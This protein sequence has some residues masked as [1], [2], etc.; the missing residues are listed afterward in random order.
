MALAAAY[1]GNGHIG[2]G[3][4]V[5]GGTLDITN[6]GDTVTFVLTR[7]TGD[8]NDTLVLYLDTDSAGGF[9]DTTGLK[10]QQDAG[11]RAISG[12]DGTNG[13]DVVF[14]IVSG[15]GA[16]YA[17]VFDA[18]N[19]AN[20]FSLAAGGDGSLTFV[21]G[22]GGGAPA[23][24]AIFTWTLSLADVGLLPGDTFGLV[25]TYLNS[26]NAFRSNEAIG[27]SDAPAGS[28][29]PG[30]PSTLTFT[31]W[32]TFTSVGCGD[33]VV[34]ATDGEVCDDG[35]RVAGDGCAAD[36]SAVESGWDCPSGGG[37]CTE[38]CGDGA[39]VG[40]EACDDGNTVGGDGCAADCSAVESGWTCATA[41]AACTTTCGDS[42]VAGTEECDD[43]GAVAGDGCSDQCLYEPGYTCDLP[44]GCQA[45]CGT[46]HDFATGVEGWAVV[47]QGTGGAFAWGQVDVVALGL[48]GEPGFET[49]PGA[50]LTTADRVDTF[51][52]KRVAVPAAADTPR[53]ELH[54]TY[55]LDRDGADLSPGC[56]SV[57][58]NPTGD[59]SGPADFQT[60]EATPNAGLAQDAAG[61]D[62]YVQDLSGFAGQTVTVTVGFYDQEVTGT[63]RGAFVDKV[64]VYADLD[65]DGSYEM[66]TQ[67]GCDL[68]VDAD[69][70]GYGASASVDLTACSGGATVD[71]DD[72]VA[73]T[74]PGA[75]E[76]CTNTVDDNC[77]GNTDLA[78]PTC[79][80]DCTNGIDDG[81]NGWADC[82][83]SVCAS[84]PFCDACM[85]GRSWTFDSGPGA[86]VS[87]KDITATSID[88]WQ[89]VAAS[90]TWETGG[91]DS[92]LDAFGAGTHRGHLTLTVSLPSVAQVGPEPVLE[93]TYTHQGDTIVN[94]DVFGVCL[95]DPACTASSPADV[96]V[97]SQDTPSP[98]GPQ[99]ATVPLSAYIG[100][101]VTVTFLYDTVTN[102]KNDN[103]GVRIDAVRIVSDTDADGFYEAD[104]AANCDPCWDAD[105][106]GYGHPDSPDPAQCTFVE[107]DCDDQNVNVHPVAGDSGEVCDTPAD[108]DCDGLINGFDVA[109]CGVEDCAN[110]GDDNGDGTVDCADPV[111]AGDAAC[112]VCATFYDFDSGAEGWQPSDNLPSATGIERGV[113]TANAT[114]P[115]D[116]GWETAL[117]ANVS[118]VGGTGRVI[119]RLSRIIDVPA[120]MPGP[121]LEVVY[122]L[123]GEASTARDLVGVCFLNPADD[124][125]TCDGQVGSLPFVTGANTPNPDPGISTDAQGFD[126]AF[127]PFPASLVGAGGSVLAVVFYDT[128]D[129]SNN[130][131]P[132]LYVASLGVRSDL[133]GDGLYERGDA[134]CDHCL[135]A[136]GDG[137]SSYANAFN[138][139]STCTG[140]GAFDCSLEDCDDTNAVTH[141]N[142][143]EVC[144]DP[145]DNNCDGVVTVDDA[146]CSV[147]GDGTVGAGEECDDHNTDDGDGC[148]SVCKI[149]PG[150]LYVT[151]IH[152]PQPGSNP[153]EQWI[154]LYNSSPS[155]VDLAALDLRLR[156]LVGAEQVFA[157]DCTVLT[158]R[159][160]QPTSFYVITLGAASGSDGVAPDA[161]CGASFVLA[162]GGD[163]L[164][165]R[166]GTTTELDVVDYR[167]FACE[168]G[169][170]SVDGVG[171]SLELDNATGRSSQTNDGA[172]VW[173]LASPD[174]D[175]S[176]SGNHRG[177]PGAAGN[178]AEFACDG[179]DDDCDG[180][181]D[182]ALPDGD[183][184]GICN[185]RDCLPANGA[186]A[187]TTTDPSCADVD[188]DFIT[189]CVDDCL[190]ADGDGYGDG[191]GCIDTDCDDSTA[192]AHPGAVEDANTDAAGGPTCADAVDNDCDGLV[193]CL[194][195]AGCQDHFACTGE[196]CENTIPLSCGDVVERAPLT[197]E[198]PC[199]PGPDAVFSFTNPRDQLVTFEVENI[200]RQR[201]SLNLFVGSCDNSTCSGSTALLQPSCGASDA[202]TVAAAEGETYYLVMDQFEACAGGPAGNAGRVTVRCE[203]LCA[204]CPGGDCTGGVDED[205]D[206]K[207]DC[208]DGD[209][210]ADPNCSGADAD[211]DGVSNALELTC[212]TNP[213]DANSTPSSDDL[214]DLDSPVPDGLLN[215][216]DDDDDGDGVPDAVESLPK[217]QGGTCYLNPEPKNDPTVYPGA[218]KNCF[219]SNV[220]ADCDEKFDTT[221]SECGALEVSCGDG[222]DD[223]GDQLIDCLDS[224]CITDPLCT[225]QDW[226]ADGVSNGFELACNT[227]PKVATSLP[228][229]S[230]AEDPDGDNLPNCSDPDDDGD[231]FPDAEEQVCG[232][233]PLDATSVPVDTDG[234]GQCDASDLDDD[235][236]GAFDD[237][238]GIC[239]SDSKDATST[240]T[241]ATHDLDGDGTCNNQDSDDDGDGWLDLTEQVC[242]TDP[243]VT[244]SNPTDL[245]LDV[246][247]DHVCDALDPDDD[248]DGW[249]DAAELQCLTDPNNA[250][251]VPVDANDDG[252]CDVLD[253]DLDG[254]GWANA[255]EES[256]GTD[257]NDAASN[258]TDL[259]Q[260]Q[261]DDKLCDALDDDDDGDGW[262]DATEVACKTDPSDGAS[263][264]TDTDGDT[265][266]DLLDADDDNDTWD[267]G[268]EVQC[269]T[270]PL[271]AGSVPGDHDGDR[272][273]DALDPQADYDLDGW[274]NSTESFCGTDPLDG[275]S[276][277]ADTD[278]DGLCDAKDPDLDGDG[279]S[280]ALE[281]TC[282]ADPADASD[283]PADTDGD[284]LCDAVDKDDDADGV[285]DADE[286]MCGKDPLS[287]ESLPTPEDLADTD[288]DGEANCVDTDDDGDGLDDAIE[289]MLGSD[290]LVRDTDGDGLID[291]DED[292]DGSGS[293][294]QGETDPT[295]P[296]TDGDGLSD[297][298][299]AASCYPPS[300][301]DVCQPTK[302]WVADTDG[303]GLPDGAE[304]T[305]ADGDTGALETNPVIADTDGDGAVDGEE[306]GCASDPLDAAS[307]PTDKDEDGVCDGA[308]VDSDEDGIADGVETFCGTD[309]LDATSAPALT[310][311]DDTDGDG[312][313]NCVDPDDD[314]DQV[315]DEDELACGVDPRDAQ[316][317]PT[318]DQIQDFDGDGLIDCAD[319]DDDDDG[320]LDGDEALYGTDPHDADT[321]D[322]GLS[323][324]AEVNTHLTDPT[325]ADTDGDGVQDGTE[326][327][328]SQGL[329]DTD[330]NVFQP[331]EDPSTKT[332]PTKADTDGDQVVDGEEDANA[333]GRVD[334]GEG[335]PN[336]PADGER[337]TDGD[338]LTDREEIFQYQTDPEEPDTDGDHLDDKLEIT[339][340]GT[341]PL[342]P[343]SDGGGVMD[344]YEVQ[345]GTDP[346]AP[347]DDFEGATL[348]GSNVFGCSGGGADLAW[349]L[350]LALL[351]LVALRRR[352]PGART[353]GRAARLGLLV[354]LGVGLG[355]GAPGSARA[356]AV[357]QVNIENFTPSGGRYRVFSVEQSQVGP[358]WQPY[359]SVLFHAERGSLKL[360]AG[361]HRESL[362][363]NAQF[364][365]LNV[366]VGLFDRLQ[367][368]LSLPIALHAA[369]GD[370]VTSVAPLSG[371]GLGDMVFRVRTMILDNL[372][373]GFGLAGTAGLSLPVGDGEAFRGDPSVGVLLN[374][375]AD[376][377]VDPVTLTLNLGAKFRAEDGQAVGTSFGHELTYGFGMEVLL[378]KDVVGISSELFGRTPLSA[379]FGS[380]D[381]SGL[382]FLLGPK[383]WIIPGLNVQAAL[384]GGFVQGTGV[385][386]FRAVLG[387]Q[388]APSSED[389]DRDGIRDVND[390]CPLVPEDHDGFA[391]ADGCPERDNDQDGIP[392]ER[393]DCPNR[394]EDF[395]GNADDDGCP[396]KPLV[397]DKDHDGLPD[398]VD[399]CPSLKETFNGFQDDDGC[400]DTAP[401][402]DDVPVVAPTVDRDCEL[403]I[404]QRVPFA[405]GSK[406]LNAAAK[407]AV[408]EVAAVIEKNPLIITVYVNGNADD[409]GPEVKNLGLSKARAKVVVDALVAAGVSPDQLI[410]RGFGEAN[411]IVRE[412]TPEARAVNRRV[413]FTVVLGGKCE[414]RKNG[415]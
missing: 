62:V 280:N 87:D 247:G 33:G 43:G 211:G 225:D 117:N 127:V 166:S 399:K 315:S 248:D 207:T 381:S 149:E 118:S 122:R 407:A 135:D 301:G 367:V 233:Q 204:P 359:A 12:W 90:G 104:D 382:E 63:Y 364:M 373:G 37:A 16:D 32:E 45:T 346:T 181:T 81:G 232:S 256:C 177:S 134:S 238:E 299:E 266:C 288:G 195:V 80:E 92:V 227:D 126:H 230:E 66:G 404:T 125:T 394:P 341:D 362:V 278:G 221:Q 96:L 176:N 168:L 415:P 128:I 246:D 231:G 335:D 220:D 392:D 320:I 105:A 240:P 102:N 384:G 259:G 132:G 59:T 147:C 313:I 302:G 31:A 208:D 235:D 70:D 387:A 40:A 318:T 49:A 255:V 243:D 133:D 194:D 385:P 71:C 357:P 295:K 391:D 401:K 188:N 305:N 172:D 101:D 139:P 217:S 173:C 110:D 328:R 398:A 22:G 161:E 262:G 376:F 83:D 9:A 304:D 350:G 309:P 390:E 1:P 51:L 50:A 267:D 10:D 28:D 408:A 25:G 356:G 78:D 396:D 290:P 140:C 183:S 409:E 282:G 250:S 411:P 163:R 303:D 324:G 264:P 144:A 249:T 314:N 326:L 120:D 115:G 97:F 160:I 274:V 157:S 287:A 95:D 72:T 24:S 170:L 52:S 366:G 234:D 143:P 269:L 307:Q 8:L 156:N 17:I 322:D 48:V 20:L 54:L 113:S 114:G 200:Q 393:D 61:L 206:G 201:Y 174:E 148:S 150:S 152:L 46:L 197:D 76:E 119:A 281:E 185:E 338:G 414:G 257:P 178:C 106:D 363:D 354:W 2:F 65:A 11:R 44:A 265:V 212:G 292:T 333:N 180:L 310:D 98:G 219:K 36:C 361:E 286:V 215:C 218:P 237:L 14:P 109:D 121:G 273:C 329:R 3:G 27:A 189:D 372:T 383:W 403:T 56:L 386:D 258:P 323:D 226:D 145:A 111:C 397:Y 370:G 107:P 271:D 165:V 69:G 112:A 209:C 378:Y 86:W 365:D 244:S 360:R 67:A 190:D 142:Q 184:D 7:G 297:G 18:V 374:L 236:D 210:A 198:I 352:R 261:D 263:I 229:P 353:A 55:W 410:G 186:C 330:V 154:E 300:E 277:P 272:I 388:W 155:A 21:A 340:F 223:D 316:A 283:V 169:D 138:D 171:R 85:E 182:E 199:G 289:I 153:G 29:N 254:D 308:Q 405:K 317:T 15:M 348:S 6:V 337:D 216:V 158:S 325:N 344:G 371:A 291:G 93:V 26:S 75:G 339:V 349:P 103:P 285:P 164:T 64:E 88:F 192:T 30:I 137:Y 369:S 284:T 260:D 162:A 47:D 73:A 412:G 279:W 205:L 151:E 108:D 82:A 167:G 331:D 116:Y 19:G 124:P 242:G 136:D 355:A 298:V 222:Q 319:T 224:D 123:Q 191:A 342:T 413:D 41:G 239:G 159:F 252:I 84:D 202:K 270:D 306:V 38:R 380:L 42:I 327:G 379:P 100:G 146:S 187:V 79:V 251:S 334:E 343:D 175:Y 58:V 129:G 321:D 99:T 377:R 39:I 179:L 294:G 296:D 368:D 89:Y 228:T 351:G 345:N 395:N 23:N 131:N 268:V 141:P 130:D 241:D 253:Q 406:K 375:I 34:Q 213:D 193:D 332:D 94:Q 5:G 214:Q 312:M 35:N 196:I 245:G 53:P 276:T 203:E 389:T 275:A 60:C 91:L 336:N 358:G 402:R 347:E 400:P 311:L 4:P 13:A 293:I 74:N 68:C 77:D 57:W